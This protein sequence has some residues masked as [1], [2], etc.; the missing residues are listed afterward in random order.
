MKHATRLAKGTLDCPGA[1]NSKVLRGHRKQR[2][3]TPHEQS[4]GLECKSKCEN[5]WA[6]FS[7]RALHVRGAW[8]LLREKGIT[9]RMFE[10]MTLERRV[11]HL[12]SLSRGCINKGM[13]NFLYEEKTMCCTKQLLERAVHCQEQDGETIRRAA[14]RSRAQAW[15][16]SWPSAPC[17][18]DREEHHLLR[19]LFVGETSFRFCLLFF[20]IALF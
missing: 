13:L 7:P 17:P 5:S 20:R 12:D 1:R 11:L 18:A 15:R 10:S 14:N 3:A 9:P 19:L 8:V 6:R 4:R 16:S 2:R